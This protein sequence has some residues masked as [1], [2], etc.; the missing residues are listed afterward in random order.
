MRNY[1]SLDPSHEKRIVV[2]IL[3]N[4]NLSLILTAEQNIW[5]FQYHGK[6]FTEKS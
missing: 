3:I 4:I 5:I 2:G 1:H 6:N